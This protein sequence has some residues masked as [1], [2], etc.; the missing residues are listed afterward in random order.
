MKNWLIAITVS[1]LIGAVSSWYVTDLAWENKRA[2][3][4]SEKYKQLSELKQKHYIETI[5]LQDN[6]RDVQNEAD[7]ELSELQEKY[8][9]LLKSINNRSNT[10]CDLSYKRLQHDSS[11]SSDNVPTTAKAAAKL[12]HKGTSQSFRS[13]C[14]NSQAR[15]LLRVA[16]D[17]DE[18]AIKYN[19]LLDFYN[20]TQEVYNHVN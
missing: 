7:K 15:E 8:D 19:S 14:S 16:K 3:Y 20:K 1:F 13:S 11:R 17:C 5:K 10:V 2:E 9:R 18:L 4:I 6:L 12:K